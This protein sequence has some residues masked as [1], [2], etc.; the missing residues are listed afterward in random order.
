MGIKALLTEGRQD[1]SALE[2]FA[3]YTL[4]FPRKMWLG[5][6]IA[7]KEHPD[8]PDIKRLKNE[9]ITDLF[10]HMV[11]SSR[12][13]GGFAPLVL[14]P[15]YLIASIVALPLLGIGLALKEIAILTDEKTKQYHHFIEKAIT[16]T[17]LIAKKKKLDEKI[18]KL[19]TD[20]TTISRIPD[21]GSR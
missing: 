17:D 5:R 4:A 7:I 21:S 16:A 9:T 18:N 6:K 20:L 12:G 8:H 15:F 14:S 13:L 2:K 11:L 3:D 1:R 19:N 10:L